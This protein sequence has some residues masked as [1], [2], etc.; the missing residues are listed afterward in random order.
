A[1]RLAASTGH[2]AHT[3][4]LAVAGGAAGLVALTAFLAVVLPRARRRGWRAGV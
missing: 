1:P 2:S 3:G 4:A